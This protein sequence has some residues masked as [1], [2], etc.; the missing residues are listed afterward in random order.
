MLGGFG[1]KVL[2]VC[3]WGYFGRGVCPTLG[4]QRAERATCRTTQGANYKT[5][6]VKTETRNEGTPY[7]VGIHFGTRGVWLWWW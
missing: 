3:D 5:S 6:K 1:A 4:E 7:L 2:F